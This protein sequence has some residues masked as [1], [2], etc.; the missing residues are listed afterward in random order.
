[1]KFIIGYNCCTVEDADNN[2]YGKIAFASVSRLF[3]V[4]E[5]IE[6][7]LTDGKI[8]QFPYQV[9]ESINGQQFE[10]AKAAF[11]HATQYWN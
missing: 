8:Y 6:I 11:E 10:S 4:G 9:V 1:M 7:T 5:L 2:V 3:I